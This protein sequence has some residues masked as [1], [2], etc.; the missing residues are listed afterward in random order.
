MHNA[1]K[2]FGPEADAYLREFYKKVGAEKTQEKLNALVLKL[3]QEAAN[4]NYYAYNGKVTDE[5]K[6]GCLEYEF[7]EREEK[8]TLVLA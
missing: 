2:S 4:S 6:L 3:G 1:T 5:M 8:I 7:L